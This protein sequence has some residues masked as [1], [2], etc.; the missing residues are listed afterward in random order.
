[1]REPHFRAIHGAIA[2][3]FDEREEGFEVAIQR[4]RIEFILE[5]AANSV[6]L[7]S[8][9]QCAQLTIMESILGC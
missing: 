7:Y 6:S 8:C 5:Q 4:D 9:C 3:G 2:S 1:M